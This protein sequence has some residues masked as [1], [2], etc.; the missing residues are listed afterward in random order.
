M[1]EA[2]TAAIQSQ[3][4]SIERDEGVKILGVSQAEQQWH[5]KNSR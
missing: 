4:T 5:G 2:I 3:L 1:N